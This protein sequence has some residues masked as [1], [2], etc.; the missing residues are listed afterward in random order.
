MP[1]IL[2]NEPSPE[3]LMNSL[4]SLG[5]SFET[6][7]ADI[8]DNSISA[9]AKNIYLE[10][11]ISGDNLY[12]SILDDGIGMDKNELFNA[13][14]YGSFKNYDNKD[15]GRF[16]LGLKSASLSQC[17]V[18]TVLSKKDD[19]VSCYRR[20][21]DYILKNKEWDCIELR[22]DEF[23]T[24]PN[25]DKL[26]KIEHGTIVIW[27]NFDIAYKKSEGAV[28]SY[29]S[30]EFD[31]AEK[32]TRLVFHRFINDKFQPISIYFNDVK[33]HGLDLF[34]EDNLKTDRRKPSIINIG[35]SKIL[36]QPYILPHVSDI[37]T[38]ELNEKLGGIDWFR[39]DQG[40]YIY[41]NKRLIIYG[42]W[43]KL[44][45]LNLSNEMIKYGRIRVDIPN[46]LDE[47]R[48]IDIKKQNAVI[49]QA[50]IHYLRQIV[51]EVCE[52]SAKKTKRRAKLTLEKDNNLIRNKRL[53]T[54]KKDIFYV[55]Q[56]SRIVRSVLDNLNENDRR[57][58]SELLEIISSSLPLL[59]INS[60][61]NSNNYET[62]IVDDNLE[63]IISFGISYFYYIK[64]TF[65]LDNDIIFNQMSALEPFDKENILN[66]IKEKILNGN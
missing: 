48:D 47:I 50:I 44:K 40:F 37:S 49:P 36:V 54:A 26:N 16:G 34:L 39:K 51:T 42:T 15:L 14:K 52:N 8:I 20:D 45:S 24:L 35:N 19:V 57:S 9:N 18:L 12:I 2:K 3:V 32:H 55:N 59:D 13:M 66:I 60:S 4:R 22:H 43:F 62:K 25:V 29:L 65:K 23:K 56:D 64:N 31:I 1:V 53:S 30:R 11:P 38:E 5:Y 10:F 46:S 33:I 63:N 21:V 41:R 28:R 58:V 7:I 17:K 27:E 61:M 6:A